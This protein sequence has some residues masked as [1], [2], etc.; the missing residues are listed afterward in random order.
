VEFCSITGARLPAP[1]IATEIFG[2]CW[3]VL[4]GKP[5]LKKCPWLLS[6][7]RLGQLGRLFLLKEKG[8]V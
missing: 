3:T 4:D 5:H 7:G 1:V 2:Q 6:F 8:K